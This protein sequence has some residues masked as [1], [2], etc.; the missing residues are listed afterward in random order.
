[1]AHFKGLQADPLPD[2]PAEAAHVGVE[3]VVPWPELEEWARRTLL[4]PGSALYNPEHTHLNHATVRILATNVEYRR[5]GRGVVGQAEMGEPPPS[6]SAWDK[7]RIYAQH[8]DWWGSTPDFILTLSGPY[9]AARLREGDAGAALAL[10]EHELYHCA[11]QLDMFGS[12][13]FS[14]STGLPL[15]RIRGHDVEEFVGVVRRYGADAAGPAVREMVAAAARDP[16]ITAAA[17][18]PV[19]GTRSRAA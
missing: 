16:E 1:M 12:P 4:R 7:A 18:A 19:C 11:Q 13:K 5:R 15:W 17:L 6:R 14:Q 3:E 8:R 10:V 9:L 2:V